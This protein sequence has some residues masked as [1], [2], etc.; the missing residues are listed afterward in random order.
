MLLDQIRSIKEDMAEM[1][2]IKEGVQKLTARLD[3]S[4]KNIYSPAADVLEYVERKQKRKS[5]DIRVNERRN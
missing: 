4:Y 3:D 2:H 5:S 1:K